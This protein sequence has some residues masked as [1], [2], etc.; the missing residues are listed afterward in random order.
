MRAAPLG[1]RRDSAGGPG[2]G[3]P[4]GR[5]GGRG[6]GR[7]G[8]GPATPGGIRPVRIRC[9]R[10]GRKAR[11]GRNSA[12][13]GRILNSV[14]ALAL[15]RAR[16]AGVRARVC[17]RLR[18]CARAGVLAC[19]RA[20]TRARTGACTGP[21]IARPT[22]CRRGRRPRPSPSRACR[23]KWPCQVAVSSGRVKWPCPSQMATSNPSAPKK[24]ERPHLRCWGGLIQG[25]LTTGQTI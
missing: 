21:R 6:R 25:R 14:V 2:A 13:F 10:A 23:V 11:G 8:P 19:A 7:P 5:E 1:R 12:E 18:A 9:R 24:S 17:P 3:S 20:R 16:V 15:A 4:E 22:A